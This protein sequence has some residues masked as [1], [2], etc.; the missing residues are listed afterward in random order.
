VSSFIVLNHLGRRKS[1]RRVEN[2]IENQVEGDV[3][4][5]DSV[6]P[7]FDLPSAHLRGDLSILAGMARAA[8]GHFADLRGKTL[9]TSTNHDIDKDAFWAIFVTATNAAC[10][11][12]ENNS[13][14]SSP[15]RFC[16]VFS[17]V[18]R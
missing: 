6:L 9:S 14:P 2:K 15:D 5:E 12:T 8:C 16:R 18:L 10:K 3:G 4:G 11:E 7:A 13:R 17:V 1:S